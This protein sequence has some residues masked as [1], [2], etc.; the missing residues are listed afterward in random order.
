MN[1]TLTRIIS[2]VLTSRAGIVN[3]RESP[4]WARTFLHNVIGFLTAT[5]AQT[6]GDARLRCR[7]G[8]MRCVVFDFLSHDGLLSL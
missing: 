7:A 1:V 2:T 8:V 4:S 6:I 5:I 3:I